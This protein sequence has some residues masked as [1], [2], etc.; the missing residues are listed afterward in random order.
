MESSPSTEEREQVIDGL[1][2]NLAEREGM[3]PDDI[4]SDIVTFAPYA[5]NEAA[6]PDYLDQLA[7]MIGISPEEMTEYALK[8]AKEYLGE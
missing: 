4:L 5:E 2:N 7:E 3:S 6:N 8:K 1:V